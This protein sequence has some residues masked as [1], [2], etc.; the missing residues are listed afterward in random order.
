MVIVMM[1][2]M[3]PMLTTM[4][5]MMMMMMIDGGGS[6]DVDDDDTHI[7][8]GGIGKQCSED[9]IGGEGDEVGRLAQRL[10]TLDKLFWGFVKEGVEVL[11]TSQK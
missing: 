3:P 2:M 1:V 10:Q 5:M 11:K 7:P 6:D 4:T 9:K 8:G